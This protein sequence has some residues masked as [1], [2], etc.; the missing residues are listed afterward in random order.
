MLYFV[1]LYDRCFVFL[2]MFFKGD[3]VKILGI[4][5]WVDFNYIVYEIGKNDVNLVG[6]FS[7]FD[8]FDYII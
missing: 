7:F 5:N 6:D 1:M 3:I 2:K 8:V 4:W